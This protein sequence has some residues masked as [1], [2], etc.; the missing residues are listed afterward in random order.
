MVGCQIVVNAPMVSSSHC[1]IRRLPDGTVELE[2][3]SRNGTMVNE[4][5]IKKK[6]VLKQMDEIILG[7]EK[8]TPNKS[9]VG[10]CFKLIK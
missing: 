3:T 10:F 1:T 8:P 2:D 6:V 4:V 9:V 5:P 7:R